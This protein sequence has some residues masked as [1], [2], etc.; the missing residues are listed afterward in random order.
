M[1][2]FLNSLIKF[3]AYSAAGVVILLAV[4][5]GLFRLFLPTL[6]EYQEQIKVWASDA[7]GMQVEFSGMD[8]RWGLRG[9]ELKF[10]DAELIRKSTSTRLVAADEV[11]VGVGLAR[12]LVDRTLVIDRVVVHDT[13]IEVRQL[14]GGGWWIQGTRADELLSAPAGSGGAPGRGTSR[15]RSAG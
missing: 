5:V 11:S 2:R 3:L 6:P 10:Y 14:E 15:R 8:A 13:V 4:A 9:P 1:K 12:L 7:I